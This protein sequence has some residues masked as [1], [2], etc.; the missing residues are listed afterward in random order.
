MDPDVGTG[1]SVRIPRYKTD[2]IVKLNTTGER[3]ITQAN[4]K[5]LKE[6]GFVTK[7]TVDLP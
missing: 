2:S 1:Y 7:H 4:T 5:Q 3:K 6:L